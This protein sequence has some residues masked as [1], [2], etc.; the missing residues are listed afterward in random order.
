MK[1]GL[2]GYQGVGKS[3]V[4]EW[5]TG[6]QPDPSLSHTLQAATV[7]V[8]DVRVDRL[9]ELFHAKKVTRASLEIVDTPGLNRAHE[10]NAAKLGSIREAGCLILVVSAWDRKDPLADLATFEED[11]LLADLEIVSGRV[12]RLRESTKKPRP[13][14]E[15][16]LKELASLESILAK[17]EAGQVVPY[18]AM[19]EE[20]RKAT[21]SF[22]LFSEKPRL[23]FLNTADDE[24][25]PERFTEG[26]ELQHPVIAVPV[27]L[28]LELG[29]MDEA[30]RTAF[31]EE[32]NVTYID[33]GESLRTIMDVSGQRLY[34]TAGEKEVRSWMLPKGATAL[35][36]A[37]N[38][39]TDLA[40]GFI[41]CETYSFEDMDRLGSERELKAH[42]LIR[43]E[44][45]DYVMREGDVVNIKFSV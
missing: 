14:R 37:A 7:P 18:D 32:L 4:F 21:R 15:Q 31:M 9:T 24:T 26:R 44:P 41:R 27:S 10:G 43:Q 42:N 13:N 29:R 11:L 38:I 28:Q 36:A 25:K 34:F 22:R 23:I 17:L 5:L 45:K 33:R 30:E 8:P 2:I 6:I 1:I 35:D 19:D 12:E 20:Q 39:H 40:R 16:E 3:S